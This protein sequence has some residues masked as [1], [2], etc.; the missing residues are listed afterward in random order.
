MCYSAQ[1]KAEYQRYVR[2][3]G[4]DID[5]HE[6]YDLYWR[7]R[8]GAKLKIPRGVDLSFSAPQTDEERRIK[9][10]IDETDAEQAWQWQQE[11]ARQKQRLARAEAALAT[12]PTKKAQDEARIAANKTAQL[13]GWLED[14]Q[15]TEPQAKDSRI[16]PGHYAPVMVSEH[17]RR[18]VRLMRYQCRPPGKP[19]HY[20]EPFPGTYNARRDNLEGSFWRDLFGR[21]HGVILISSFY[22]NVER[23]GERAV[24]EFKPRPEHDLLVACLWSRWEGE[25]EV[26]YS[27]AAITDDPPAEVAAAGHDRCLVPIKPEHLDAWLNPDPSNL[28]ALYAI[29]DDRDRPYYEHRLVA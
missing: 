6:Y 28:Q 21:N 22:E 16:F 17:G 7:R 20:D 13:R 15:R 12:K 24:V 25:G 29:L 8:Q 3:Y 9:A 2:A 23:A 14:L 5:L 11:L 18:V 27:F 10:L 4:A 19:A 26:L 1:I